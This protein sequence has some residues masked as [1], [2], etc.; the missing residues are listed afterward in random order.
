MLTL[1]V[2]RNARVA[3]LDLTF[4]AMGDG[5]LAGEFAAVDIDQVWLRRRLPVDPIVVK[6]LRQTIVSRSIKVAHAQQAVE[7][8]HIYLATRGTTA[9]CVMS[10]H[11][12]ILDTKNRIATKLI[13]PRMDAIYSVSESVQEWFRTDEDI[14]PDDRFRVLHNGVDFERLKPTRA[15]G[16][17]S[18]RE[19]L[20]IAKTDTLIGMVGNF[21]PDTRKDQLT[22]CKA[23]P[24]VM[25]DVAD[26]HFVF[27]GAVHDGSREYFDR[28]LRF[29]RDAGIAD[30]VHFVG[31]RSDVPDLLRELDLFVFSSVQEGLPVAAVEALM[32]GVPMLV[33][34]IPP[35]LEVA[36]FATQEGPVAESFNTG[37]AESLAAK[38]IGLLGN[39]ERLRELGQRARTLTPRR[40]GIDVHL[41]NLRKLYEEL[42]YQ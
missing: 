3:G 18:L 19:E 36:G 35:L 20:G 16:T 23:L 21:Y 34:D 39:R 33:S 29:C 17:T 41:K 30:R 1:D 2:C 10:L 8:I 6:K 5:D 11:N 37:D 14:E 40:F 31:K 13:V 9:K 12:F 15:P 32:L 22:V 38:L 26:C 24:M 7:A 42:T 25:R 4:A 27:V 28:C